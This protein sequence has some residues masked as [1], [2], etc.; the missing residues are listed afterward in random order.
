MA[1]AEVICFD[2]DSLCIP[3]HFSARVNPP[4]PSVLWIF[5]FVAWLKVDDCESDTLQEIR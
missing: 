3:I 2:R 4:E 1:S 5:S